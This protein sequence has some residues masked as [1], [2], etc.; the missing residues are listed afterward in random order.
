MS[1]LDGFGIHNPD[2]QRWWHYIDVE[3]AEQHIWNK[4][5]E[6]WETDDEYDPDEDLDE[7]KEYEKRARESLKL[8]K[9]PFD[10]RER[11][12]RK[13]NPDMPDWAVRMWFYISTT[14]PVREKQI[15][16][17]EKSV[18]EQA[19]VKKRKQSREQLFKRLNS[20]KRRRR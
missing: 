19:V 6:E 7:M 18:K 13:T 9:K 3:D 4:E 1:S 20:S 8:H 11:E 17:L 5:T 12:L 16:A 14:E 15:E 10:G 2:C